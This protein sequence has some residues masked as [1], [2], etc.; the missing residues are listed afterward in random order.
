[1]S[2]VPSHSAPSRARLWATDA[3]WAKYRHVIT[4][5]YIREK[6]TLKEIAEIMSRDYNFHAK[7]RMFKTRTKSWGVNKN[8]RAD[9][10]LAMVHV[11]SRREEKGIDSEFWRHGHLV[12]PGKLERYLRQN[13][14]VEA[15]L[16]KSTP[17]ME[18]A[19]GYVEGHL[20]AHIVV[21]EPSPPLRLDQDLHTVENML[22]A[23]RNYMQAG[24]SSGLWEPDSIFQTFPSMG[25]SSLSYLL[26]EIERKELSNCA[27]KVYID[28]LHEK[29]DCLRISIQKELL[30]VVLDFLGNY[31]DARGSGLCPEITQMWLRQAH[32]FSL[33]IKG[34]SHPL[35]IIFSVFISCEKKLTLY[36]SVVKLLLKQ[37]IDILSSQYQPEDEI[38][39]NA[40]ERTTYILERIAGESREDLR[41]RL[42]HNIRCWAAKIKTSSN[43]LHAMY[44][45]AMLSY[46]TCNA[47][48]A[49]RWLEQIRDEDPMDMR[50]RLLLIDI[51]LRL[52]EESRCWE[53]CGE[54]TRAWLRIK[55]RGNGLSE[56]T[57]QRGLDITKALSL[58]RLD[59]RLN[60]NAAALLNEWHHFILDD[61]LWN[62]R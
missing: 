14:D 12:T 32:E 4:Q 52:G 31:Q 10:V 54:M 17:K 7:E 3:E 36:Y 51:Y 11:R 48:E 38:V 41:S 5:L 60:A 55:D 8:L 42:S 49:S 20:P 44:R 59:L 22:L 57:R 58:M 56:R 50:S 15:K 28:M 6:K 21:L 16:K 37:M 9:E 45:I 61:I 24:F 47:N 46:N 33:A 26:W 27:R 40:N 43:R 19:G 23:V 13:P 30:S 62:A 39:L 29:F 18:S 53:I 1:M 2:L 25:G 34:S 35:S